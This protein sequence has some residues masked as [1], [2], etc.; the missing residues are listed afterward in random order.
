MLFFLSPCCFSTSAQIT[1]RH[2]YLFLSHFLDQLQ[3]CKRKVAS[4]LAETCF[5]SFIVIYD[6]Y[7]KPIT[8]I[9]FS[10]PISYILF[11]RKDWTTF[12]S[13]SL[14]FI[15][16]EADRNFLACSLFT[17]LHDCKTWL[18]SHA[19]SSQKGVKKTNLFLARLLSISL[20]ICLLL[21]LPLLQPL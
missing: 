16:I 6:I 5:V 17:R 4:H 3:N 13:Q 10:C 9:I 19:T 20:I 15:A 8:R 12:D 14:T 21:L 1:N 2:F 11:I 7:R 18:R